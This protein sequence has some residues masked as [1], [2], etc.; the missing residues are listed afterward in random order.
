MQELW[1]N[2]EVFEE[3]EKMRYVS[4]VEK[5]GVT[6]QEVVACNHLLSSYDFSK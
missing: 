5:I 4:S 2:V 3:K 1:Q 6:T